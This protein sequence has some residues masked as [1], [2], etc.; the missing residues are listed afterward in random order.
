MI[1][2]SRTLHLYAIVFASLFWSLCGG[3]DEVKWE[4]GLV[5]LVNSFINMHTTSRKSLLSQVFAVSPSLFS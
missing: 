2:E 1:A 3:E 4:N 5:Y